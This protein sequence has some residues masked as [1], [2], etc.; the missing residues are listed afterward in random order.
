MAI[1]LGAFSLCEPDY[2]Q[3]IKSAS[4]AG[5]KNV[6]LYGSSD[7]LP[8]ELESLDNAQAATV[9]D[10]LKA[11]GL[12]ALAAGG[13]SDVMTAE[14]I[15]KFKLCLDGVAKLGA[16]LFDTGSLSMAGKEAAQVE[17]ETKQF[18]AGMSEAGDHA[19]SLG[20]T[21]CLETHGGLTG[22]MRSCLALMKRLGHPNVQI[23]YDP[24]NI[25]FYEGAS[26]L[27]NL[28]ELTPVIG[29]VHAKDHI[30]GKDSNNFPTVGK[31]EVAYGEIIDTLIKSGYDGCISVERASADTTEQ[32]AQELKDAYKFLSGLVDRS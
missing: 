25:R 1:E 13:G 26:P 29:H 8:Y 4:E 10:G 28:K 9:V 24:A 11:H 2:E 32:R 20:I 14:G 15:A 19:A 31:G 12:A 22:T 30:G 27:E 23:G 21:I 7:R 3:F 16:T 6:A 17:E 5:F 18:C